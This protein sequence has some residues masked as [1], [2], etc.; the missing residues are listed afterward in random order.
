MEAANEPKPKRKYVMTPERKA[1][2]MANLAMARLAPKEKVYRKTPRRYAANIGNLEK[3]NAKVRQQAEELRA[4]VEGLFPA[5]EVLPPP[6]VTPYGPPLGSPSVEKPGSQELEQ[7]TALIAKRLRKVRAAHRREGRRIMRVLTAAISRSHPLSPEEACALVHQL[8]DCL[9]GSHVVAE[10]RRL[11]E[12]IGE[13]L[14]K[15]LEVRYG[16]AEP[17]AGSP[18][19][20]MVADFCAELRLREAARRAAHEARAAREGLEAEDKAAGAEGEAE[21]DK[22]N[23]RESERQFTEPST[24]ATPK[25]PATLEEFQDLLGRALD[26]EGET[27]KEWL[28]ILAVTL[29]Q[30]LQWWK[31]REHTEAQRL[32]R[33]FQEGAA[34]PPGSSEDLLNRA[35]DVKVHLG[36]NDYFVLQMNL[37]TDGIKENLERWLERRARI[38][39]SRSRTAGSPPVKPPVKAASDEPINGSTAP[40]A[41]A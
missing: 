29:W 15:M 28:S 40:W 1:K 23:P 17:F 32:E 19:A 26:L 5:P 37:T 31:G 34:T 8:L 4:K 14:L 38:V 21:G 36:M 3:A 39:E 11:N 12:K 7:A 22:G 9:D 20:A 6:I 25:L 16:A 27:T 18:E 30:R 2:L 24:V 35:L 13:L 41:A 10:A 33:L